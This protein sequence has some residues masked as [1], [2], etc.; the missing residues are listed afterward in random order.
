MIY[1][2]AE[3]PCVELGMNVAR[4][5]MDIKP[6]FLQRPRANWNLVLLNCGAAAGV[7]AGFNAPL[8]GVFFTL[9]VM[10]SAIV[11]TRNERNHEGDNSV[12]SAA[13]NL[14]P[15]LLSSVLSALISR[16]IL[17]DALVLSLKEYSLQT[18]LIELPLY[19][20]L[21]VIS[22]FVAFAFSKSANLSQSF[23]AGR[24]GPDEIQGVM[25]DI[26][27]ALKPMIGGLVCGIIA[28]TFPQILFFGY[29]TLNSLLANNSLPVTLLLSLLVVKT[30]TTAVSV[31]SGLV[32]GT[33]APSL[34]LGAMTGASFHNIAKTVL[35][36]AE[37][38]MG[39]PVFDLADVPAYAMVGAASVLAAL[40]R[41]PLTASL[42]LFEVT[43]DYD[44]I[45]PLM[46]SAGL[47]S[48]VGDILQ[49][50]DKRRDQDEVS[51]GDLADKEK[52]QK[53]LVVK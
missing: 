12:L 48:L 43:R 22:G 35:T 18:P 6:D 10:Q 47:G 14:T 28:L 2:N 27:D 4:G 39:Y 42:L 44:V 50:K 23:F 3:G 40:F 19:L 1:W 29:E 15:V 26:P 37:T 33:F 52:K 36:T 20:V 11:S 34:F 24:A 46:A 53:S 38:T 30:F 5:C 25:K 9:E 16:A 7:A 31:G 49:D 41:A 45:L 51:W 17:G 32:G 8:A 13:E 21:G